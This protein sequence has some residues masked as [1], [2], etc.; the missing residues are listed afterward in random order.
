MTL[1]H[2]PTLCAIA[3]L[4]G[5]ALLAVSCGGGDSSTP[6]PT[7]SPPPTS[8]A[9]PDRQVEVVKYGYT[10]NFSTLF[11]SF[12][13][14]LTVHNKSKTEGA[15]AVEWRANF[16]DA[17]GTLVGQAEGT[18]HALF[19]DE[20]R[21]ISPCNG[22]TS[23]VNAT[24]AQMQVGVHV[25]DTCWQTVITGKRP[26]TTVTDIDRRL[27]TL[28]TATGTATNPF[29]VELKNVFIA[30]LIYNAAGE[31]IASNGV[32]LDSIPPG[33]TVPWSSQ[34]YVNFEDN[35]V[36]DHVE[37]YIEPQLLKFDEVTAEP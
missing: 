37:A 12:G 26:S 22:V 36:I 28:Y 6:T 30:V 34:V 33:A 24:I 4:G 29:G 16:T 11:N 35:S 10:E 3:V 7:S 31:I 20:T 8:T 15:Q 2:C 18:I 19:P 13:C 27:K 25:C 14:G 5:L 23:P 17:N 32:A 21:G 1:R 9:N